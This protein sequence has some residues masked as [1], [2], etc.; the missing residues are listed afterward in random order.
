[1]KIGI[2]KETKKKQQLL[3]YKIFMFKKLSYKIFKLNIELNVV[4]FRFIEKRH[5]QQELEF[6]LSNQRQV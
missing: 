6:M 4:F 5:I 1:M 3:N 2:L